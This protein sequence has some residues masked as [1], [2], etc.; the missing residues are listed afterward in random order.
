M[1]SRHM[2]QIG[3]NF[4]DLRAQTPIRPDGLYLPNDGHPSV[5]GHRFIAAAILQWIQNHAALVQ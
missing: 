1:L 2:S 5:L 3:A 4:V